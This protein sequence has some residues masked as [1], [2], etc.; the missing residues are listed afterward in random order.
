MTLPEHSREKDTD[1]CYDIVLYFLLA[2][3]VRLDLD[4]YRTGTYRCWR[5]DPGLCPVAKI[6]G[7]DAGISSVAVVGES[8]V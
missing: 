8:G 2:S 1:M 4:L 7:V 6:R 5:R 3:L